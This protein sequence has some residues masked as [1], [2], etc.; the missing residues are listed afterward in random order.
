[1]TLFM[2][3]TYSNSR[4][5]SFASCILLRR[6]CCQKICPII[7]VYRFNLLQMQLLL[8]LCMSRHYWRLLSLLCLSVLTHCALCRF[9]LVR[10]P[11]LQSIRPST[12]LYRNWEVPLWILYQ[13]SIWLAVRNKSAL[14]ASAFQ[15]SRFTSSRSAF[16]LMRVIWSSLRPHLELM[17]LRITW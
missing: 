7:E 14:L 4:L 15:G 6:L 13:P 5:G 1:M 12:F 9:D 8:R 2:L 11:M 16:S 17:L 3:I 10:L